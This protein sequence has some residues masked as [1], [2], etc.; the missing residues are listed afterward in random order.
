[1]VII[2]YPKDC[3]LRNYTAWYT[4]HFLNISSMKPQ[5]YSINKSL[6]LKTM[7]MSFTD[8]YNI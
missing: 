7:S 1:V 2:P 4:D 6:D 8:F 3:D 5:I